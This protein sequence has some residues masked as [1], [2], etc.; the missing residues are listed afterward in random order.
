MH[1]RLFIVLFLLFWS[2]YHEQWLIR[3][4]SQSS[5]CKPYKLVYSFICLH[6]F[7]MFLSVKYIGLKRRHEGEILFPEELVH[8]PCPTEMVEVTRGVWAYTSYV[9]SWEP[10]AGLAGWRAPTYQWSTLPLVA[11]LS[12]ALSVSTTG[13]KEQ[14]K[15]ANFL[16]A[17]F[18]S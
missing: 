15:Q 5:T 4:A 13:Y 1:K 17:C 6:W 9:H 8:P 7:I 18:K 11:S 10:E 14:L 12:L 16:L 2:P 3:V